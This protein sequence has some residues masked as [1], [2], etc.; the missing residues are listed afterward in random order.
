MQDYQSFSGY[1][2][3]V[4]QKGVLP[5]FDEHFLTQIES[6]GSNIVVLDID[7]TLVEGTRPRIALIK[8]CNKLSYKKI[9]ITARYERY[10]KE[11][12][13]ELKRHNVQFDTLIMM[14]DQI[15]KSRVGTIEKYKSDARAPLTKDNNIVL[16]IGDKW[17]DIHNPPDVESDKTKYYIGPGFIKLPDELWS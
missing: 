15:D 13:S 11:T 7:G 3:R 1:K 6:E 4:L 16:S 12:Y 2:K 14:P 17:A 8:W 10:R 9:I 5:A